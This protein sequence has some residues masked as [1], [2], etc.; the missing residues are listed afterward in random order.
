[1]FWAGVGRPNI[2]GTDERCYDDVIIAFLIFFWEILIRIL[3]ESP[4]KIPEINTEMQISEVIYLK[5][6][7]TP[8]IW[9]TENG[10]IYSTTD[11]LYL[12]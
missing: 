5:N 12:E 2:W 4:Q 7:S 6:L 11:K 1:M 10:H 3:G 8:K 9:E